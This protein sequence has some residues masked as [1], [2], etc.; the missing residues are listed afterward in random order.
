M[1]CAVFIRGVNVNLNITEELLD[2]VPL[3][4]TT[5]GYDIFQRLEECI[6]KV[7]LPWSKL[8]S[9]ATDGAPATLGY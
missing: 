3:K 6:E 9:L 4:G 1:Q 8:V 5:T 7:A 2:L